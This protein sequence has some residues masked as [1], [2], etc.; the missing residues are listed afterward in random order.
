MVN[1]FIDRPI[2]ASVLSIIITLVGAI[3]IVTLPVAQYPDRMSPPT[4]QVQANYTGANASVVEETVAAPIEQEVNGAQDMIYM[5][6]V[7][8]NDGL[9]TLNISFDINRDLELA[10]V[11]VQ[12]R[13][14]LAQ[15]KLP[16][17]VRRSG[18]T[19]K[20]QSPDMVVAINLISPDA[21]RDSLFLEN[22][23]RINIVDALARIPGAGNVFLVADLTYGMRVW[24]DPDKLAKLGLTASDVATA[25][26]EQNVQAPAGQL[27]Q[28]PTPENTPFQ[29]TVQVKGRLTDPVEFADII[30]RAEQGG[31]IVR[32]KDIG[33]V[34]LG[35]QSYKAFTRLNGQPTSTIIIYQLPGANAIELV[36]QVRATM[37]QV[38]AYFPTGMDYRIP[39]DT[40][41]FVTASI[42]EVIH[43][44]FEAIAL[45]LVVVFVFLQN[46]RATVIPMIAVPVSLV[47]TFAF[48]NLF[49]FSINT[50]TLFA[51]V[52]AIGI[53][54]DDAIVVVEAVQHKIDHDKMP[55]K[56]AAKAAMAEVAG[57][58]AAISIVLMSVFLPASFMGGT[59]GRLY[60][61]FALTVAISVGLS[62]INALTLSPALCAVLLRP[63]ATGG[64][65]PLGWFFRGFNRV[66]DAVTAGYA[67]LVRR[68]IR[69]ALVT[70]AI[71]LAVY[72]GTAGILKTLPTGFVPEEDMGYFFV[73]V[74]L[75]EAASL[76]R[77]DAA[78]AKAE[79]VLMAIP[80]IADVLTLGG[81]NVL[82][83][84]YSSY[85]SMIIPILTP[86]EKR[87]TPELS[88]EAIMSRAQNEL[89]TIPE[90]RINVIAAPTI[91]GMGT[92]G[93]YTFELQNRGGG[94]LAALDAAA[95]R[96][97]GTAAADPAVGSLFTDFSVNVPQL[98]FDVDRSKVKTQGVPL[99]QV[100]ESMQSYLGGLYVN[101]FNKFGRTY[102]VMLQAEPKF[103]TK[104]E[105]IGRFFVRSDNGRMLPLST[106]GTVSEIKGPEYIRRY[107]LYRTV[108]FSSATA[109][110]MSSGQLMA[111][112]EKTAGELPQ[113]YG[114]E[115]TGIAFQEKQAGAQSAVVFGLALVLVFLV[116]A[117][118]YESWSIPFAVIFSIPCAVFGA[119]G[120]Q[121]L[122]GFD[123]NVYAQI[124]LVVLIGLAA[125]NA[126]LIVEFAKM[127]HGQ[128]LGIAE[129]A[130]EASRLRLRPILMTSF[131]FIL[132]VVPLA[133][134]AG[135][136]GAARSTMGTAVMGGMIAATV[137]GLVI[138]PVLYTTIQGLSERLG[139]TGKKGG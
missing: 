116:L 25:L 37:A 112:L 38:S 48:F 111:G 66:F 63:A 67:G 65:G 24:L 22:Y 136:G 35:A 53:V 4:V 83:G 45:V 70:L 108:E 128:G 84:G 80:G 137:L 55:P 119:M 98:Y 88:L 86:W 96:F 118:Q 39:Y 75:P 15:P 129:A 9:M 28:P 23:A 31:N 62:A 114:Y 82:I 6:S 49:G 20:K 34:E 130:I 29:M 74:G 131:A 93:G 69:L 110:G 127:R 21:S 61:Q 123:N 5:N 73:N 10:T 11:D 109:P 90:A 94:T 124:G 133:V 71:L 68:A 105:D 132:G 19:V 139:G 18:I 99:A 8:S 27:G 113:G 91:P 40:T 36:R 72:A 30:L 54:V 138:I 106:L 32:I 16:D 47:G 126:I 26:K 117:A 120:F 57:P 125:K 79:A 95:A 17:D 3:S 135:A 87:A 76:G 50:T 56:Q 51:L 134:A 59:T 101:D 13:V 2:F 81:F 1:F 121:M 100:F 12:N 97:R 77:N 107:N 104:P 46:W 7:S 14:Q 103:R 78:T 52:L 64:G 102:R 60:Q 42:E 85:T 89:A 43:T 33:R 115:W 92:T 122:R 41:K 58:V 44:L